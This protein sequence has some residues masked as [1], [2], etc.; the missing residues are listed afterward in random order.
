M[1]LTISEKIPSMNEPESNFKTD[2]IEKRNL[3]NQ[4]NNVSYQRVRVNRVQEPKIS[5]DDILN[6]MGV[7]VQN[8]VIHQKQNVKY[9]PAPEIENSYIYNKYFKDNKQQQQTEIRRPKTI[10]EYR[11]MLRD[12]HIQRQRIKRIKSTK[13]LI[14]SMNVCVSDPNAKKELN[15]LFRFSN[16]NS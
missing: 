3:I 15:K 5:Y 12:D 1:E 9:A 10:E 11:S 8:G 16:N 13:L 2:Y 7:S 6:N 4:T 14:P